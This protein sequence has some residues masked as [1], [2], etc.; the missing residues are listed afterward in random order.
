MKQKD[1]GEVFIDFEK[2]ELLKGLEWIDVLLKAVREKTCLAI[3]YQ[4]FK[5]RKASMVHVNPYL[6]K[7]YRNRWFLLA[8]KMNAKE[9]IILALDRIVAVNVEKETE[10]QAAE[11]FDIATFFDNVIG[12]TKALK[13]EPVLIHLSANTQHAPY[14]LTKPFHASQKILKNEEGEAMIFSINV[15]LNYELE[16][17]ILGF[18]EALKVL[19]PRHLKKRIQKRLKDAV[20]SYEL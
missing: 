5:A 4:S 11:D 12:V 3:E 10:F 13:S 16:R 17:E 9:V 18:G 8:R 19:S 15:C 14:I 1:K 6:L 20:E 7:E 2:N